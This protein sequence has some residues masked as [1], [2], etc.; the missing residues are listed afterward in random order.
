MLNDDNRSSSGTAKK[1]ILLEEELLRKMEKTEQMD[2][3]NL[4]EN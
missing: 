1:Q 4:R 3:I 2:F